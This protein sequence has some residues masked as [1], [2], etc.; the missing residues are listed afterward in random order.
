MKQTQQMINEFLE[1]VEKDKV[2]AAEKIKAMEEKRCVLDRER[3]EISKAVLRFEYEE[4]QEAVQKLTKELSKWVDEISALDRK[5]EAYKEMGNNY[6][7]E[8]SKIFAF[9][10]KEFNEE[11]PKVL[12]KATNEMV[13][14]RQEIEDVKALL[15]K[16]EEE[17]RV[18]QQKVSAVQLDMNYVLNDL[19][20]QVLKYTPNEIKELEAPLPTVHCETITEDHYYPGVTVTKSNG[21]QENAGEISYSTSKQVYVADNEN[22]GYG[23]E[24]K[25]NYYYKSVLGEAGKKDI[26]KKKTL[27]DKILGR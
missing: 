5:I 21:Q 23:M 22:Y 20:E 18:A 14:A 8:A 13:K 17:L 19:L 9:A 24:G 3:S 16:K 12:D 27:V 1:Q 11:Y 10:A 25:L 6:E 26:P 7:A 15:K 4:N 2:L